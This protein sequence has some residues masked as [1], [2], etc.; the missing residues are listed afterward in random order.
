MG[1][2]GQSDTQWALSHPC[3]GQG[4]KRLFPELSEKQSMG[5]GMPSLSHLTFDLPPWPPGG[6]RE[7]LSGAVCGAQP[8]GPEQEMCACMHI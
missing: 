1:V 2:L 7:S 8:P 4:E 3:G 6:S 5:V